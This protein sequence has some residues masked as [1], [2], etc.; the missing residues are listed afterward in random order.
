MYEEKRYEVRTPL[1]DPVLRTSFLRI[2]KI[3]YEGKRYEVRT[4]QCDPVLRT[5]FLRI[6]KI[7]YEG[8]RYEVRTHPTAIPYFV[9]L[10]FV[11]QK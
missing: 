11:S 8:K 3:M 1:C 2:S 6:S 4:P 10:S 5:S 9:L 7:M